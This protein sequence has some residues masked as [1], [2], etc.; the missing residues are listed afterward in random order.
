M[1][2]IF[3]FTALISSILLMA[4]GGSDSSKNA[5]Y[6]QAEAQEIIGYTNEIVDYINKT[7]SEIDRYSNSHYKRMV[8]FGESQGKG[9]IV[10]FEFNNSMANVS[11]IKIK[12][13]PSTLKSD[14]Q[15]FEQ[16]VNQIKAL[17]EELEVK[18]KDLVSHIKAEDYKDDDFK[19][20]Q[21][22][23]KTTKDLMDSIRI[24]TNP[25]YDRIDHVANKAEEVILQDHPLGDHIMAAK[26][27]LNQSLKISQSVASLESKDDLSGLKALYS[28]LES[29]VNE[30]KKLDQQPLKDV[31]KDVVFK[32]FL[33]QVE[34]NYLA[35]LRKL[36]RKVEN[37]ELYEREVKRVIDNYDR[38]IG[39]YNSFAS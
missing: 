35:D 12:A 8:E 27:C 2:K 39:S 3:I 34:N 21:V 1:N 23:I 18:T 6:N 5:D 37:D 36:M 26:A 14:R 4:C 11:Y 32:N 16:N 20:Y 28:N 10:P 25:I 31:F 24:K 7:L 17:S 9:M 30:A 15:F 33:E 38:V 29:S 19:K 13:L 22:L